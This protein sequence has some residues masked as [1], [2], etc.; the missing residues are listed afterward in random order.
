MGKSCKIQNGDWFLDEA[1][2]NIV[3]GQIEACGLLNLQQPA[4]MDAVETQKEDLPRDMERY[5][6]ADG[7]AYDFAFGMNWSGVSK[8][9]PLEQHI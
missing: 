9:A 2:L 4:S 1:L 6:D 3:S 5:V 8:T 7:N